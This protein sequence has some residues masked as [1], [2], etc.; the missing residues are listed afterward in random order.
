MFPLP[1][2]IRVLRDGVIVMAAIAVGE[3]I[4]ILSYRGE[5]ADPLMVQT[6]QAVFGTVAFAI[7]GY[8]A[9]LHRARHITLV[10]IFVWLIAGFPILLG[11]MHPL[12]WITV[13]VMLVI[14]ATLGGGLAWL[15][16]RYARE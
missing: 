1:A 6:F 4:A 11:T 9:E 15:V 13:L 10:V 2:W 12:W 14:M 5:A 7:I 8:L 16:D 3:Q